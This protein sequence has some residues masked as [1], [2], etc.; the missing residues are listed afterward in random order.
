MLVEQRTGFVELPRAPS[1][2]VMSAGMLVQCVQECCAR[3]SAWM[4][5]QCVQERC[6]RV[7]AG[8]LVQCVQERCARVSAEML[9]RR[10]DDAWRT[11]NTGELDS[12]KGLLFRTLTVSH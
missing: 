8:M 2:V 5:V 12:M 1:C 3:V 11:T 7:S 6:A 10:V 9:V 4:L